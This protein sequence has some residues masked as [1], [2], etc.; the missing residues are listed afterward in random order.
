MARAVW[1]APEKCSCKE[2]TWADSS[3]HA[4]VASGNRHDVQPKK[5]PSEAA[6]P[7]SPGNSMAR[8]SSCR[9]SRLYHRKSS[10]KALMPCRQGSRPRYNVPSFGGKDSFKMTSVS[11]RPLMNNRITPPVTTTAI[12][13][14]RRSGSSPEDSN[15][16]FGPSARIAA[17][18]CSRRLLG[19]RS[20]AG[21]SSSALEPRLNI[22][23]HEPEE[24]S[25]KYIHKVTVMA[26]E[27][28]SSSL[29]GTSRYDWP[30]KRALAPRPITP[31][32][33]GSGLNALPGSSK[34]RCLPLSSTGKL[35]SN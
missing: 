8:T 13:V 27:F 28:S 24:S 10:T 31:G 9:N 34:W 17:R 2:H 12:C 29:A 21:A 30:S 19:L 16:P 33:T 18:T 4:L 23:R 32:P 5:M 6:A 3:S 26:G 14:Q 35:L 25:S 20:S 22:V 11:R 7:V 1:K 15:L